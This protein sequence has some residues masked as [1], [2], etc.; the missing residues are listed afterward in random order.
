MKKKGENFKQIISIVWFLEKKK[1]ES[2]K[3]KFG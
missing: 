1:R 2:L 3:N